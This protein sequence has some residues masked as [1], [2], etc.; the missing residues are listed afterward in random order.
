MNDCK[1]DFRKTLD[2]L[3]DLPREAQFFLFG[4]AFVK[5]FHIG[6]VY[7]VALR[8]LVHAG[9]AVQIAGDQ[10]FAEEEGIVCA[11]RQIVVA[12][13]EASGVVEAGG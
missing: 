12:N 8:R 4:E 5:G 2:R 11:L 7:V 3:K 9:D 1:E 13:A 6:V 10:F